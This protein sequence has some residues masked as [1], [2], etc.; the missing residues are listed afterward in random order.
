MNI[1]PEFL[2]VP[3]IE[4]GRDSKGRVVSA[5]VRFRRGKAVRGVQP[6]PEVF[7]VFDED[8][9]GH[10]LGLN[11]L[12]PVFGMAVD[13]FYDRIF[14]DKAG[15]PDGIARGRRRYVVG[16]QSDLAGKAVERIREAAD[17]LEDNAAPCS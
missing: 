4:L 14:L 10:L 17:T 7:V 16:W 8:A 1:S 12:E 2:K 3:E 11:L 5:Y 6:N 9:D 15:K 13:I